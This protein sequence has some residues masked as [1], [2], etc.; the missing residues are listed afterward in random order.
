[1][2]PHDLD[3]FARSMLPADFD[4]RAA[5]IALLVAVADELCGGPR[6]SIEARTY[7]GASLAAWLRTGGDLA[8]DHLQVVGKRGSHATP[9]ALAAAHRN[10]RQDGAGEAE[11]HNDSP[12]Q[13]DD[14]NLDL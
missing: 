12:E 1:M 3:P 11:S 14:D 7:L 10:E 2:T 6:A 4:R 13:A 5:R 8:K 9:R